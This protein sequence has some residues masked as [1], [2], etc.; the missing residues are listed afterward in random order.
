MT[1][2][3]DFVEVE[4]IEGE[5]NGRNIF[6][7]PSA[8]IP[9]PDGSL[10]V[11]AHGSNELVTLDSSGLAV[12]RNRGGLGGFDRPYGAAFLPDG[13]LF[14]TEFDG[15]KVSR[16]A[17]DGSIKTFGK[18]GRGTDGF[19]GPHY[20]ATDSDGY[21]YVVDFGNARVSKFDDQGAFVLTFG[22][23]ST[24][25]AF[26]GFTSPTG[27]YVADGIVYVADSIAK[28]IFKFDESGN[29]IGPLAEGELHLPEGLSSWQG[30]RSL[31]VADTDRL[32][33][34]D[35]ASETVTELYRAPS[36]RARLVDAAVDYNGNLVACDFDASAVS[37]LSDVSSLSSGLDV[38]IQQVD[39]SAFPKVSMDVIVRDQSGYPVVGLREGNFYLTETI[40]TSSQEDEGGKAV[41]RTLE[42][43]QPITNANYLGSGD[44]ATDFRTVLVLE[45]SS[46]MSAFGESQRSALTEIYAKLSDSLEGLSLVTAGTAPALQSKGDL[47]AAIRIA[48]RQP[49]GAAASTSPFASPPPPCCLQATGTR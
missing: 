4:R 34:V 25:G 31:L 9:R 19:I 29:Y 35:L 37:V 42:T 1:G 38:E 48:L 47:L 14:V 32:V 39:S 24:D 7:R 15:D 30:G 22:S 46:D 12:R 2:G 27:I 23:K 49:P 20:V 21:L 26:P 11:V 41:L 44:K 13:T 8:V 40:K 3:Y 16:I 45:R 10:L 43:I 6:E 18:K 36:K 33:S 5:A 17:P 28:A